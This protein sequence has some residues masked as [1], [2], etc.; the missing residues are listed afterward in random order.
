MVTPFAKVRDP[1]REALRIQAQ[2]Q[3]ID[4]RRKKM[5]RDMIATRRGQGYCIE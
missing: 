2:A 1:W 4:R 5:G 3:D